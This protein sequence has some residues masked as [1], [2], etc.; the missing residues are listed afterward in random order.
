MIHLQT[1]LTAALGKRV[2]YQRQ[3]IAQLYLFAKSGL[4]IMDNHESN[5]EIVSSNTEEITA[6]TTATVTATNLMSNNHNVHHIDTVTASVEAVGQ[7]TNDETLF[8]PPSEFLEM[9]KRTVIEGINGEEAAAREVLLDEVDTG[10]ENIIL[11]GGPKFAESSNNIRDDG[12]KLFPIEQAIILALCLDVSNSNPTNDQLTYEEMLVYVE[13][14]L[15]QANNWMIHSTALL[16]RSWIEFERRKTADRAM[17]QIQALIDQHSTKLTFTQASF[18][19]IEESAP[20]QDRMLYIYQIAYPSICELK[21]DLAMKYLQSQVF[22]SALNYFREL[23]MWDE[24]VTCYQLLQKPTRAELIVREQLKHSESP[25]MLTALADLTQQEALYERAWILS[26]QRYARAKRTLGKLAY[27]RHDYPKCIEHLTGA[28]QVQPLVHTS[29]YLKGISAMKM[30]WWEIALEA[31]IR[32]VQQEA[33]VGEAW[34]NLGAIHMRLQQYPKAHHALLEAL[35]QKPDSWRILENL[36]GVTLT[37][38]YYR[39][40]IRYMSQLIDLRFKQQIQS[41][42][43]PNVTPVHLKE[44]RHLIRVI[45]MS[46]R[47]QKQPE[48]S[49]NDILEGSNIERSEVKDKIEEF[50]DIVQKVEALLTKITNTL[51]SVGEI[52]DIVAIFYFILGHYKTVIDIRLK[53]FRAVT[54]EVNWMTNNEKIQQVLAV[55]QSLYHSLQYKVNINLILLN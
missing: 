16:E 37:L 54:T 2:K 12:G 19:A 53:E 38:S 21:R 51:K 4:G 50:P 25:Y 11:E 39:E 40:C 30:E 15:Q 32:C 29:W 45:T 34:A 46:I 18:K 14:V 52:W 13:R 35:K 47:K 31:F 41:G 22:M 43:D 1:E 23:E 8:N 6:A 3:D 48:L 33:E 5:S 10:V 49:E 17:L 26:K 42:H 28:L 44:L 27:D 20:M 7:E 9:G 24:V 55:T 36:I